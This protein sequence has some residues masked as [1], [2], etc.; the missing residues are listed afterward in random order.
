MNNWGVVLAEP[1]TGLHSA[2]PGTLDAAIFG[3]LY[4]AIETWGID[5]AHAV[6]T[7]G[8]WVITPNAAKGMDPDDLPNEDYQANVARIRR[9]LEAVQATVDGWKD[10][11]MRVED[12]V[13]M[14]TYVQLRRKEITHAEAAELASS[15]LKKRVSPDAWRMRLNRWTEEQGYPKVELHKRQD[16]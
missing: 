12:M 2:D 13:L 9:V 14:I 15:F 8:A 4:R 16:T 6:L 10:S 3:H 1:K 7:A 5:R 11:G